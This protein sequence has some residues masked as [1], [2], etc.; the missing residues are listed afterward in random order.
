MLG[1][2]LT[3][4]TQ[5]GSTVDYSN[6]DTSRTKADYALDTRLLPEGNDTQGEAYLV[7][8]SLR[9]RAAQGIG[10]LAAY[11]STEPAL[12]G[13]LYA[14]TGY[15]ELLLADLFCS[16]VPLSIFNYQGNFIYQPGSSTDTVY[17]DAQRQ[18]RAALPLLTDSTAWLNLARVGRGRA[19]LSQGLYD[20]AAAAVQAVPTDYRY[21]VLVDWTGVKSGVDFGATVANRKGHVGLPYRTSGDPRTA[22]VFVRQNLF[23]DSLFFPGK[24][25]TALTMSPVTV[26]SG[27]EARL[28]EA[29]TALQSH[30]D[31]GTMLTILN[32]LRRTVGLG[33][34]PPVATQREAQDTLFAERAA[35]LFLDGHRLG[36][37]RRLLRN[38]QRP[39]QAVFP[40]GPYEVPNP[41]YPT[42]GTATSLPIPTE[43]RQIN[44]YFTGC[45]SR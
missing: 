20:S 45:F 14:L 33:D 36:D 7:L 2:E 19:F 11:D 32:A 28:I 43:E 10:A 40:N 34:I 26:A 5:G 8:Q 3:V 12:R 41:Q 30:G 17:I 1:D 25:D 27:I 13:H 24:Y 38:Y 23:G 29:E 44:P 39:L 42:Y 18:F 6:G 37:M 16:G 9:A 35:W 15:A 4:N 22:V 21:T 31:I